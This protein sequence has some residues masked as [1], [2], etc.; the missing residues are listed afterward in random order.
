MGGMYQK[1]VLTVHVFRKIIPIIPHRPAAGRVTEII[2]IYRET[3]LYKE[4]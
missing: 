1:A 2:G 3:R 4:L